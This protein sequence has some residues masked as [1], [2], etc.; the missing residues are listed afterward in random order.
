MHGVKEYIAWFEQEHGYVHCLNEDCKDANKAP[1]APHHIMKRSSYPKHPE[2]HNRRN[3]I[4]LCQECHNKF[5][6]GITDKDFEDAKRWT[7]R[8]VQERNLKELFN[9]I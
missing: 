8:W 9:G 5:H 6:H 4:M 2:I 7:E 3:L 1:H